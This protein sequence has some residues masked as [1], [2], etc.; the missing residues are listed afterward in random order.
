MSF[1][2]DEPLMLL[3]LPLVPPDIELLPVVPLLCEPLP[4]VGPP[5]A[6]GGT[7]PAVEPVA[8]EPAVPPV[9]VPVERVVPAPVPVAVLPVVPVLPAVGP[10]VVEL[11]LGVPEAP[12]WP[13]ALVPEPVP[14]PDW[15]SAPPHARAAA[16]ERARIL[17]VCLMLDS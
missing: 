12:P 8:V 13:P 7:P 2:I 1:D 15:A 4:L 16:A 14:V 9:A 3:P 11:L 5:F 17:K 6:E 10:E